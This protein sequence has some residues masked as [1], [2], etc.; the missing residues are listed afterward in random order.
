[1]HL[2]S[3]L[4]ISCSQSYDHRWAQGGGEGGSPWLE[5]SFLH[6]SLGQ[7]LHPTPSEAKIT[8]PY[9]NM[10][11]FKDFPDCIFLCHQHR[12]GAKTA[13]SMPRYL[14]FSPC[15]AQYWCIY[16]S[17]AKHQFPFVNNSEFNLCQYVSIVTLLF[18]IQVTVLVTVTK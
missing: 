16:I 12:K 18:L 7:K 1:M 8:P 9:K 15:G 3:N 5:P 11:F 10:Q 14:N 6:P 4:N 13:V 17:R 2:Y